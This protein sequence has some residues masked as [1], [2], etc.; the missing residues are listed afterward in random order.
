V[1]A[2]GASSSRAIDGGRMPGSK[3]GSSAAASAGRP[4]PRRSPAGCARASAGCG[5]RVAGERVV[6]GVD[7]SRLVAL[8]AALAFAG[9]G[10]VGRPRGG[11]R[12]LPRPRA[13]LESS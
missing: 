1:R 3:P 12:L 2:R 10:L 9:G 7:G 11:V 13:I 8:G 5:A 4:R 6:V